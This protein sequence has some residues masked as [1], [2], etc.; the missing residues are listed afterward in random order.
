MICV[1]ID[2]ALVAP[3]AA[4]ISVFDRGFLY[5]DGC[6][7]VLRTWDGVARDLDAHLDRLYDTARFLSLRTI[8]RKALVEA[9]YR[10]IATALEPRRADQPPH[11][12]DLRIRILLTR[13]PGALSERLG[14]LGPGRSIVIVEPLPPQ[15]G[16][17]TLAT[18]DFPVTALGKKGAGRKTLSYVEHLVARELARA[19][20]ADEAVRLDGAGRVV[21]GATCNLFAVVRGTVATPPIERGALPGI[22]RA[23][24]L[25]ICAS[26]GIAASVRDLAP[27]DLR[28]ADELFVTSSLRGVVRVTVLD[29]VLCKTGPLTPRLAHAYSVAMRTIS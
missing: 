10:T 29:G 8:E 18:V 21:E 13:G 19:A 26:E 23:R 4:R 27:R 7:E 6:F 12:G 2:G 24:V 11:T 15:P 16:E 14:E 28:S 22:V 17:I 20:G 9:I 5:G 1:S 3:D 25:Q